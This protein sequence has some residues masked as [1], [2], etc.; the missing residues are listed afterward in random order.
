VKV[1]ARSHEGVIYVI[2]VNA[3]FT[4]VRAT[5]RVGPLGDRPLTVIGENRR[6]DSHKSQFT[7]SFAPLAVH[8]YAVEPPTSSVETT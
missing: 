2:A 3:G 8:V 7:D 4:S 1:G 6:V 5:I